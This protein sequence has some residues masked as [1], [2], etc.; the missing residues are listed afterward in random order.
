[1]A[2]DVAKASYQHYGW[3]ACV[4]NWI[5]IVS[6]GV[7]L[8]GTIKWRHIN[9]DTAWWFRIDVDTT[10]FLYQTPTGLFLK[11]IRLALFLG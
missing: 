9:V 1:M 8:A 2:Q 11:W 7:F 5:V 3:A 4:L 6:N 10:S